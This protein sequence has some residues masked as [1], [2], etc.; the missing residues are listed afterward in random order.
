MSSQPNSG[1]PS[2]VSVPLSTKVTIAF[3]VLLVFGGLA[4]GAWGKITADDDDAGGTVPIGEQHETIP[5]FDLLLPG[6]A[7]LLLVVCAVSVLVLSR[8][9]RRPSR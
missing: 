3:A 7:I 9:N 4:L 6:V 8:S 5:G 2:G 1:T